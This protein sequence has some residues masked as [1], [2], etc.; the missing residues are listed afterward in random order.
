MLNIIDYATLSHCK[1]IV[2]AKAYNDIITH[3]TL[4]PKKIPTSFNTMGIAN[5]V[6]KN[7]RSKAWLFIIILHLLLVAGLLMSYWYYSKYHNPSGSLSLQ[8]SQPPIKPATLP[9]PNREVTGQV[10]DTMASS[11][12]TFSPLAAPS[13]AFSDASRPL[14]TYV[15]QAA[16][17]QTQQA[18]V[19]QALIASATAPTPLLIESLSN[20]KD[21]HINTDI[22]KSLASQP[23]TQPRLQTQSSI[24]IGLE[25]SPTEPVTEFQESSKVAVTSVPITPSTILESPLSTEIRDIENHNDKL[26]QLIE[27][28]NNR[29]HQEIEQ[30]KQSNITNASA[31]PAPTD[32]STIISSATMP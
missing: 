9:A 16:K 20:E 21:A 32:S 3:P 6:N 22:N 27:Q 14:A 26:G 11:A 2:F 10:L 13:I 15:E 19:T 5:L 8:L 1:R 7:K 28:I 4:I 29:N 31:I 30:R 18:V 12:T 24:P 25:N 17:A 23:V